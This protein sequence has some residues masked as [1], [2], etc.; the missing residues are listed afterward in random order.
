MIEDP[1]DS[2]DE[3]LGGL[4]EGEDEDAEA[5]IDEETNPAMTPAEGTDDGDDVCVAQL[6]IILELVVTLSPC[7]TRTRTPQNLRTMKTMKTTT[8]NLCLTWV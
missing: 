2:E 5:E 8:K 4:Y 3:T 6:F 1:S 7:R